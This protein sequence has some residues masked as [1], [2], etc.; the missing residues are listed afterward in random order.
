LIEIRRCRPAGRTLVVAGLASELQHLL[1]WREAVVEVDAV[2]VAD[3]LSEPA[4]ERFL[5]GGQSHERGL[6]VGAL[7]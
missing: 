5:G 1:W 4:V 6:E 7:R 2:H 3:V